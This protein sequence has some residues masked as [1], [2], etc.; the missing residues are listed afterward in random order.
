M[1]EVL[2]CT[3]LHKSDWSLYVGY[4]LYVFMLGHVG[5]AHLSVELKNMSN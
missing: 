2:N 5:G 3:A 1:F 4:Q